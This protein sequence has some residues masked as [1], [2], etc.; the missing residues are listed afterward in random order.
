MS[1]PTTNKALVTEFIDALF[2][3]GDLDA[4]DRYLSPGFVNHDPLPG[5]AADREG[6]ARPRKSS[7]RVP[8]LAQP[9]GGPDRR[10]RPGQRT[11]HRARHPP[12][13]DHG[14]P[15]NRA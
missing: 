5:F 8:R 14:R 12:G 10:G 7:G 4:V 3:R 9:A 11:I 1:D 15:P 13:R 6:C 2:S